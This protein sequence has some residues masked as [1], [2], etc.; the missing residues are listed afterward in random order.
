MQLMLHERMK[1]LRL[2]CGLKLEQLAEFT[3]ISSTALGSYEIDERKEISHVNIMKL[4]K[5]YGVT[6]DYLL[7]LTNTKN[8]PVGVLDELRLSDFAIEKIRVLYP[9]LCILLLT[10]Q[11]IDI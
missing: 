2:E 10:K 4:A 6:T 11:P 7:C 3:G 9:I 5:F 1:D 8:H